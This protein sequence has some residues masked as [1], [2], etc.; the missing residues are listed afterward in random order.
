M[1]TIDTGSQA[2]GLRERKKRQTRNAIHEAAF[3]LIDTQ[4]LDATTVEHICQQAD[5]SS[6]TFFNYF[7]SKA[8]AALEFQGAS[9]DPA[10]ATAFRCAQGSLVMALCDVIG[11][12]SESGPSLARMK[13]LL[14]RRPELLTTATQMMVEMREMYVS[15]AAERANDREQAQLAVGLVM[16]ALSQTLHDRSHSDR[17]IGEQLKAA[18]QLLLAVGEVEMEPARSSS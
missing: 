8:A 15:L 13:L 18:V 2:L 5:V 17:P 4:G 16:S 3:H 14:S 10:V 6:R 1:T 11:S 9:I 12:S 7:P